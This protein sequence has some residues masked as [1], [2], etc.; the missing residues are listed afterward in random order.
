[1]PQRRERPLEDAFRG[2]LVGDRG[3]VIGDEAALA[4][5]HEHVLAA[6]LQAAHPAGCAFVDV[7]EFLD[8]M[9]L[10]RQ[11]LVE[12]L[13]AHPVLQLAAIILDMHPPV[14]G[15]G[16]AVEVG[17]DHRLRLVIFGDARGL[18]PAFEAGPCVEADEVDVVG[19]EQ[20]QLRHDRVVVVLGRQVA[21]GAG[22]GLGLAHGVREVRREGLAGEADRADRRLLHIDAFAVDIGGREH[23]RR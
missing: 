4:L 21:I 12:G 13:A 20:Q 7:D 14:I 5:G 17:A 3:D 22:L 19:A 8:R 18:E 2:A 10:A 16:I 9:G 1:M 23:Q 11:A 6:Q 15:I